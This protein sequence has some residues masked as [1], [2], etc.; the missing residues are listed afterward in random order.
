MECW[1]KNHVWDLVLHGI[2]NP[3]CIQGIIGSGT[4]IV[5]LPRA[6]KTKRAMVSRMISKRDTLGFNR[7]TVGQ[8]PSV[9]ALIHSVQIA[10]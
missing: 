1:G 10:R 3:D 7:M 8:I 2:S 5:L 9:D 4:V 6:P